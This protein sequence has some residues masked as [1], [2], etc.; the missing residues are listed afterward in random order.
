MTNIE[1]HFTFRR[2]FSFQNILRVATSFIR[3]IVCRLADNMLRLYD[4]RHTERV[5]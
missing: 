2:H 1:S 3:E 4:A 5:T